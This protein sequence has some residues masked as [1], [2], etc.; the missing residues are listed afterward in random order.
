MSK[1]SKTDD[2]VLETGIAALIGRPVFIRTVTH[3]HT[4]LLVAADKR[5]LTLHHAAWIADTGERLADMLATGD[6]G[7]RGEI[8]PFPD[9]AVLVSTGAVIDICAWAHDLPRTQA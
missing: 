4:G 7:E 9:G 5:F 1:T 8:E 6:L 2:A 3:N